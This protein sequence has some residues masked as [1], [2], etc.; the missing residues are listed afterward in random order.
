MPPGYCPPVPNETAHKKKHRNQNPLFSTMVKLDPKF[1]LKEKASE[2][3]Y[4]EYS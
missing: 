1:P 2:K 4:N 3:Q